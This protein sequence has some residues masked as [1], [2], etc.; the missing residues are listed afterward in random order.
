MLLNFFV[1]IMAGM[2]AY[3]HRFLSKKGTFMAFVIGII[4]FQMSRKS[5]I[6]LMCFFM[7]TVMIEHFLAKTKRDSFRTAK[8]VICNSL[9]AF[10]VLCVYAYVKQEKYLLIYTCL[11]SS[12][13]ADSIASVVGGNYAKRV[14]SVLSLQEVER[15]LSGGVSLIGTVSGACATFVMGVIYSLSNQCTN[16]QQIIC[17]VVSGTIGM[18]FDSVLGASLQKK[19]KCRVC[20]RVTENNQQCQYCGGEK[21]LIHKYQFMNNNEVNLISNII[22]LILLICILK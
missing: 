19:Y 11:L 10:L 8:Q 12:S 20:G 3:R 7:F 18:V 1:N 13:F 16:I 22:L 4:V 21:L 17:I 6:Y 15:G 2:I 14:Y 9:P 5:Y